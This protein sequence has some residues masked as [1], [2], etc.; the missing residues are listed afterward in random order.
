MIETIR[1]FDNSFI[2]TIQTLF[3][4]YFK[5]SFG[6]VIVKINYK[7]NKNIKTKMCNPTI[8]VFYTNIPIE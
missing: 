1:N 6:W 8:K 5:Q 2:L 3:F 4:H 7:I